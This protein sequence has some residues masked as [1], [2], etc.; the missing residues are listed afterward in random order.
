MSPPSRHIPV[1]PDGADA[2]MTPGETRGQAE[3]VEPRAKIPPPGQFHLQP[4][5]KTTKERVSGKSP[6]FPRASP[7]WIGMF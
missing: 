6:L 5:T 4:S 3:L 7:P 2:E 1:P